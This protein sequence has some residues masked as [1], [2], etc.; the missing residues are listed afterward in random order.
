MKLSF[1][2]KVFLLFAG[3]SL[4]IV[5]PVLFVIA[6]AVEQRVYER[7]TEELARAGDVLSGNW[8]LQDTVLLGDARVRALDPRLAEP[9]VQGESA[10]VSRILA[11]RLS[12]ERFALATDSAARVLVGPALDSALLWQ[13][14]GRGSIVATPRQGAVPLR[15]AVWP[16]WSDGRVIGLVGVGTGLDLAAAQRLK[17]L[18]GSEV[19]LAVADSVV[20]TTLPDSVADE[21]TSLEL[22]TPIRSGGTWQRTLAGLSYL[23]S[24]RPLPTRGDATAALLFRPVGHELRIASGILQSLVGV[25]AVALIFSLLI[26][27]VASRVVARPAQILADAASGLARGRF[28]APL[29]AAGSDEIGR[30]AGAFGEM[31]SAIAEREERLRAAQTELVHREKLAAMGRLVAQLS[32]EIN[33]PIYNIQNC[34]EA[35]ERRGDPTD[36]NREFLELAQEELKRM[37]SLTR[38]FLAQ[39]RPLPEEVAPVDLNRVVRRVLQ[40]AA[41]RVRERGIE[42][43]TDLDPELPPVT[44]HA[45][46]IQEV[47]ANLVNNAIDAMPGGGQLRAASWARDGVVNVSVRDT[48]AGVSEQD[49]PHIFEAFYTTK[50]GIHGVGLGLF[51]SEGIVRGHGGRLEVESGPGAGSCFKVWLPVSPTGSEL[52]RK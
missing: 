5:V 52:A 20:A 31:R 40:L 8:A 44:A 16:V 47:L 34:L 10:S 42:V 26:A 21:L 51:V 13:G 15:V 18:T 48:G 17:E 32:H 39:S 36:P 6:R 28:D 27:M 12:E 11:R 24:V 23:Y 38:R 35:L 25:G 1:R 50:P 2:A 22:R 9:L 14:V 3:A 30:L 4:L 46:A 41:P 19:A 29:P 43:K 45:D 49:L 33:N 37:A 7:A